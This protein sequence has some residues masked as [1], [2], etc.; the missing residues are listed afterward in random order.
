MTL[1]NLRE[2]LEKTAPMRKTIEEQLDK[3]HSGWH[4]EEVELWEGMGQADRADIKETLNAIPFPM[5]MRKIK[6][7]LGTS[8]TTGIAGAAYLIPIKISD[9]LFRSA[10]ANDLTPSIMRMMDTPGASLKVDY[11]VTGQYRPKRVG[12]GGAS[13]DESMEMSQLT[14][15]PVLWT[16]N[17]R[18]TNELIE[19]AQWD[20]VQLHLEEAAKACAQ[21]SSAQSAIALMAASNGDGTLNTINTGVTGITDFQ[22]LCDANAENNMDGYISDTILTHPYATA[23]FSNDASISAYGSGFHDRQVTDAPMLTGTFKGMNL[24]TFIG[25][26]AYGSAV[27]YSGSKYRTLVYNKNEAAVCVRKRWLKIERYSDPVKDLAGAVVSFREG[28]S[29]VNKDA[30][31]KI[32]EL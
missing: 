7:F 17:T 12:S 31:C 20:T 22:D 8:G 14:V 5:F 30:I 26:N 19:D 18:I 27:M 11:A 9:V 21:E 32:T 3:S 2:T 1:L 29:T 4:P 15:T 24:Y 25:E 10:W 13:P 23:D 28:Y 16:I 6:E